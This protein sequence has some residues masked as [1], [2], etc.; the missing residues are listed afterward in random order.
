MWNRCDE[1]TRKTRR[2][3]LLLIV[4]AVVGC[5]HKT[6]DQWEQEYFDKQVAEI[7]SGKSS[8]IHLYD[9]EKT[10]A[11]LHSIAGLKGVE[12][13][14][15]EP[16]DVTDAGI[17]DV[18]TLPELTGLTFFKVPVT[19]AWLEILNV[20]PSLK[21]LKIAFRQPSFS[22]AKV[23]ALPHLRLLR[24]DGNWSGDGSGP[25]VG[26]ALM[27]LEEATSLDEL[28]LV[29]PQ[30]V[31]RKETIVALQEKLPNCKI[32]L[33]SGYGSELQPIPLSR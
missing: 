22:I 32:T 30:F 15:F 21:E 1:S 23:L 3:G 26:S 33:M 4:V 27:Q 11:L 24:L 5:D 6:K 18:A 14:V 7:K 9:S 25:W 16:T 17:A 10:D 2:L 12:R 19:D 13:L 20:S 31:E 8:H 28:I 29:G